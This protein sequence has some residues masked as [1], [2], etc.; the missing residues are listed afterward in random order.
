[1][2]TKARTI[3]TTDGEV[4]DMNS[5]LRYLLYSDCFD[6]EGIVLTSSVYHY[7]G[8]IEEGIESFRWTGSEWINEFIDLYAQVYDN[9]KNHSNEYPTPDYLK[10]IYHIGNIEAPGEMEKETDG[11]KFIENYLIND[12]DSRKLYIQTWGGTNTTARALKSI[13]EKFSD[14]PNWKEIKERIE[15]NVIIYIILDQD[16]T[17]GEYI[18]KNWNIEV[19]NDRFNFWYFAYAWKMV[20]SEL[21][22]RLQPKWQLNLRDNH[23]PLLKKYAL[24]GDGN[25]LEGELEDEQRGIDKYLETNSNYARYDF[26]SEGDSPSYFY[27]LNNGLRNSEHPEFG[28]W[29]GRFEKVS[30]TRKYINSAMDYN[31]YNKRYEAQY[32]LTRWFDDIQDDFKGRAVWCTAEN[33]E[34]AA[35]YPEVNILNGINQFVEQGKVVKIQADAIDL[36]NRD[37]AFKWWHYFEASTYQ[38]EPKV[39]GEEFESMGLLFG[40]ISEKLTKEPIDLVRLAKETTDTVEV[41]IPQNIKKGETIHLILEVTNGTLTT[42]QRIILTA[43]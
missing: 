35:H 29:G 6:T 38:S 8:N 14:K 31:P 9:L 4:D 7:S 25:I 37:L 23:G 1:M 22:T 13:E 10:S 15:N 19:I 28:G 33:F 24:I 27:M 43:R 18:A 30:G 41:T 32:S 36:N 42:Y 16:V 34:D 11:S 39:K 12:T 3:I 17:Y 2:T 21:A 20:E 40:K 26:I 5:F